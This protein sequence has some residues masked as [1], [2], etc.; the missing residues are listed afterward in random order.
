MSP[1]RLTE[2]EEALWRLA[3]EGVVPLEGRRA[4]RPAAP[5]AA[6]A[7]PA[8]PGALPGPPAPARALPRLRLRGPAPCPAPAEPAR[9]RH[10]PAETLDRRWDRRL[11]SGRAE[12]ERTVDLHGLTREAARARLL[13]AIEAGHRR[14][15]RLILVITGKGASPGPA[16][17]DLAG[18][19]GG[20]APRGVIR[21]ELPRWLSEPAVSARIAA[22]RRAHPRHGGQGAIYLVLRRPGRAMG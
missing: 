15:E 10:P 11:G 21:A 22:V 5:E 3:T 2:A 13:R 14:G 4:R 9:P 12:P 1:R 18:L 17:A 16:P 6:P 20:T 7:P 8:P 19:G